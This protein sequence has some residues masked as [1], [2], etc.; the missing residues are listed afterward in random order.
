[1]RRCSFA[2]PPPMVEGVE[3]EVWLVVGGV[4]GEVLGQQ[5]S[6]TA[7][8]ILVGVIQVYQ[9]LILSEDK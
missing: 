8:L 9:F 2:G 3:W 6:R 1:M 7:V 4:D 5:D